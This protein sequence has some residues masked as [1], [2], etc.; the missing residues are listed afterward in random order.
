MGRV[1]QLPVE[2]IEKHPEWGS[3]SA[4]TK[5]SQWELRALLSPGPEKAPSP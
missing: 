1:S 4:S 5:G 3:G 2:T